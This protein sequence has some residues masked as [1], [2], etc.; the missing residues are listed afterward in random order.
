M[1]VSGQLYGT[2]ALPPQRK[3]PRYPLD[4]SLGVLQSRSGRG[5]EEKNSQSLPRLEP[6][7]I[8]PVPSAILIIRRILIRYKAEKNSEQFINIADKR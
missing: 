7:I 2:A 4:R 8:Q 6:P 5:G 1:E 3:I